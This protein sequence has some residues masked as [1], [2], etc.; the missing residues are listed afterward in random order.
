MR[1]E[2]Q[3]ILPGRDL[4]GKTGAEEVEVAGEDILG[5]DRE[6]EIEQG[7]PVWGAEE[8]REGWS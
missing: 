5:K 6:T 1:E 8:E 2:G 4:K 7:Q 3:R